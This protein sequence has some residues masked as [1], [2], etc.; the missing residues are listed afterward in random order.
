[1]TPYDPRAVGARCDACPLQGRRVVP[2]EPARLM[3]KMIVVGE[4]PGRYEEKVGRPFVGPSGKMLDAALI[5]A[6]AHRADCFM[7]NAIQCRNDD[8]KELALAI[9]CCAPRLARELVALPKEIPILSLGAQAA[10]VTIGKSGIQKYRGF[11][12]HAPEVKSS[13]VKNARRQVERI[14]KATTWR[15][16]S[17]RKVALKKAESVLAL[18]EAR[19]AIAGRV[20]IPT[21]HPAFILRGADMWTPVMR[22]DIKRAVRW[23]QAPFPLEDEGGFEKTNDPVK[24]TKLLKRLGK[25][26]NVDIETIGVD[27]M[28]VK[29]T[30]IGVCDVEDTS[31]VVMLDPWSAKLASALRAALK[32]RTVLTHNGPAFDVIALLERH[33]I[34]FGKNEDTLIAHRAFASHMPQALSHVA[35]VYVDCAPWKL[36]FKS[37]EEKG[38]TSF[39]VKDE[40]LAKYCR[41]DVVLASLAWKRMQQDLAPERKVYELD[42]QM[43]ELYSRMQRIGI[44]VDRDRQADL[45]LRLKRRSIA[46]VREMRSLLDR[47]GFSPAKPNDVRKALYKQLK[48]PLWLAPPTPTGLPSTAAIVLESLRDHDSRAGKLADLIIRWRSANDSR[49]EYLDGVHVHTDGRV[50]ASWGAVQTGRPRTRRPNILNIPRIAHCAGCGV[51]LLD[52]VAHKKTCKTHD[53][54]EP[55]AQLRDIYIAAKGTKFVYF[56]LAQAEM[57]FAAHISNDPIFIASCAKDIHTENACILFP[58]GAEMIRADPKGKGAKFRQMAKTCGFAVAYLAEASTIYTNLVSLGFDVDMADVEMMLDNLRTSYRAYYSFVAENVRKCQKLG[59]MRLPFS[60]R[61]RYFGFF[62]KP[63]EISNTPVQGGV[64]DVMNVRL[65][66][67]EKRKTKGARL[68]I[69]HYDSAI[70]ETPDAECAD[71]ERIVK[72]MWAEPIVVPHN[73]VSFVQPIEQKCGERL[74]DF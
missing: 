34:R 30:C 11:V 10:R 46:L 45:S 27:P 19:A 43:A 53:V 47:R 54:A 41:A 32:D 24:A 7:T 44:R 49:S 22:V 68:L 29:I 61:I 69:Y 58:D 56:D 37:T 67:L 23:A 4:G 57:R 52:G 13:Q 63:A 64:A 12:W 71:M 51:K 16:K 33:N 3:L 17:S 14:K 26:V 25:F 9:P 21:V 50:H 18:I 72:D 15:L 40:D 42:M 35:S 74:S 65:L 66:E 70:Y 60:G 39:G 59:Y 38:A 6:G 20:V 28:N 31:K 1:M 36:K 55:E 48:A 73:G 62:P 2:P 5:E 8:D